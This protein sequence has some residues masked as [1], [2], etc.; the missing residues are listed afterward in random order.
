MEEQNQS[1][2]QARQAEINEKLRLKRQS[3]VKQRS[4]ANKAG[5]E[6][7]TWQVEFD[8]ERLSKGGGLIDVCEVAP[9]IDCK[10]PDE[11]LHTSR[12]FAFAFR[13]AG[14]DC[15]DIQPDE[16]IDCFCRRVH[17]LWYSK[18]KGSVL[19]FVGLRTL[20]FDDD[21]GMRQLDFDDTDWEVLPG[22]DVTVDV[23]T[24]PPIGKEPQVP[25]WKKAGFSCYPDWKE[26]TDKEEQK[27][28]NR[29]LL[30]ASLR[31]QEEI[32]RDL[33]AP[34]VETKV[35]QLRYQGIITEQ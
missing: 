11:H 25:E 4:R 28:K 3:L 13:H 6:Q 24:L 26:F 12:L 23:A 32:N 10:T 2:V 22:H 8:N 9:F 35:P 31:T 21:M 18:P 27:K 15:P 7:K 5:D 17:K 29:A 20:R 34:T 19:F 33:G 30:E 1:V 16:T 14:T